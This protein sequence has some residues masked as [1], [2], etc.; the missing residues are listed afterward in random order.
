[1]LFGG[2]PELRPTFDWMS[3]TAP[4]EKEHSHDLP[5]SLEVSLVRFRH[6]LVN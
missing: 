1:V 3:V 2:I 5:T 4:E 6:I